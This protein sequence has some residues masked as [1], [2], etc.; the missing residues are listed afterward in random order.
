[1]KPVK[2]ICFDLDDTLISQNSWYTLNT[3]LGISKELDKHL[4]EEYESGNISYER[5]NDLLLAEYM[6]HP[7]STRHGI[8]SALTSVRYADGA[9]EAVEHLKHRGYELVLISGSIDIVVNHV[10]RDLG[11]KY[12]KANNTFIFDENDRLQS[13]HTH[14]NDTLAKAMHL[15]SFCELLSVDLEECACIGDG[16]NDIEMFTRT[17]HGVT[18]RGSKIES[19]AWKVIDSLRDIPSIF[20]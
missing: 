1:M 3:A 7:D 13:I 2:L 10:A 12:S 16:A 6:R 19:E 20:P 9:R 15:E 11:F 17:K 14:G 4:Y 8:T 18:F 5:W